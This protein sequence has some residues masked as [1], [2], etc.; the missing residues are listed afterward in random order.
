MGERST[1]G[2][3]CDT[4]PVEVNNKVHKKRGSA[5]TH[6]EPNCE[7]PE[8]AG[9]LHLRRRLATVLTNWIPLLR[10]AIETEHEE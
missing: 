2:S 4:C 7:T 1:A 9:N 8:I 6:G 5:S 10:F 3:I